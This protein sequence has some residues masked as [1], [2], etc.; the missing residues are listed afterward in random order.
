VP[1]L[2]GGEDVLLENL[3]PDAKR[4]FK[5]PR[6][7]MPVTFIP[8][9]GGDI[10][11]DGVCDTLV[12]EPDLERF[13]MTWRVS[14]PLRRNLFE[15]RQTIVGETP[16]SSRAKRRAEVQGKRHYTNLAELV[17]S[18]RKPAGQ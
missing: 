12:I 8:H 10:Q 16:P 2:I 6:K 7:T 15:L 4:W 11:L 9:R 17:D 5:I 14:L 18:K 13:T 3:T 1:Y